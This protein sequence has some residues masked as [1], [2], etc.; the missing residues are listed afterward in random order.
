MR[1]DKAKI[2][3]PAGSKMELQEQ[4]TRPSVFTEKLRGEYYNIDV[5]KLIPFHKQA[6]KYFDEE[7]LKQLAETIKTH[8]IRQPLT[9]IS[10]TDDMTGMYEVV[11]GERRL[12]AAIMAGLNTVPCIII[13]DRKKAEEIAIIENI[14]RKD[15]H[16][17]E[18]AQAY[19]NLLET[20]VCNSTMEIATK[21]G[22]HKSAVVETLGLLNLEREVQEKL[23]NSQIKAR[24]LL[25]EL[26]K[27][28]NIDQMTYLNEYLKKEALIKDPEIKLNKRKSLKTRSQIFN[29]VLCGDELLIDKNRIEALSN[30]QKIELK[31]LLNSLAY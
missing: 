12:R 15:L 29:I 16:P 9:I 25:R 13:E 11:S 8:G 1:I 2:R 23:M 3:Y 22:A 7:A 18:L 4:N 5:T 14:Q 30:E 17:I 28:K 27:L 6:R 31:T 10:A 19:F 26:C 20:K 24:T 21:V